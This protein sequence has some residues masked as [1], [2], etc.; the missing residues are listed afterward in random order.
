MAAKHL[1]ETVDG[2]YRGDGDTDEERLNE[3]WRGAQVIGAFLKDV[4]INLGAAMA[5]SV[6][7]RREL[8]TSDCRLEDGVVKRIRAFPLSPESL[9]GVGEA[10]LEKLRKELADEELLAKTFKSKATPRPATASAPRSQP[11]GS[12]GRPTRRRKY[13]RE[14]AAGPTDRA[15]GPGQFQPGSSGGSGAQPDAKRGRYGG[16][17][18]QTRASASEGRSHRR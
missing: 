8:G 7:I 2:E 4:A 16:H 12:Q 5:S 18:H 3:T 15:G 17:Q 13:Y 10:A 6:M 11:Q 14:Q 9:F 1:S